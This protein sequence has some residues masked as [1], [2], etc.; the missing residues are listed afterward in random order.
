MGI[1]EE[2]LIRKNKGE[3]LILDDLAKDDFKRM[4]I[5]ERKTDYDIAIRLR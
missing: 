1:Y 3:A 2:L 5:D 4:F